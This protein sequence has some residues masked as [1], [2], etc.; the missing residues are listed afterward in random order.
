MRETWRMRG[1]IL[2]VDDSEAVR[3]AARGALE[4]A[5]YRVLDTDLPR[6]ALAL[7]RDADIDLLITEI[8]M[9]HMDAFE[10]AQRV[11]TS[12]PG[13]GVLFTS[14]YADARE[15]GHFLRK[16]FTPAQLVDKVDAIL[17]A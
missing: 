7:A 5:G 6:A 9:P 10:L 14:G 11:S 12:A 13:V 17:A 2:V 16:P 1:V 4:G 8:V 3:E 15:E